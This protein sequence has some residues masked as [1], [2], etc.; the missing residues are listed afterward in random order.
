MIIGTT[1]LGTS[2]C[3]LYMMLVS[4]ALRKLKKVMATIRA[5][6]SS[7]IMCHR[8]PNLVTEALATMEAPQVT[9]SQ[10]SFIF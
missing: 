7:N 2:Q 5:Q 1:I 3:P 8:L 6:T 4:I 9:N 10:I